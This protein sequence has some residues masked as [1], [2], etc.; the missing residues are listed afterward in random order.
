LFLAVARLIPQ[1][2]YSLDVGAVTASVNFYRKTR[3]LARGI[4]SGF[5]SSRILIIY[6]SMRLDRG[7]VRLLQSTYFT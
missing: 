4:D 5:C 6:F 3:S 2:G 1:L 7:I